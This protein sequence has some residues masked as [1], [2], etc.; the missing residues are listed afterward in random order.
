MPHFRQVRF[1]ILLRHRLIV[2]HYRATQDVRRGSSIADRLQYRDQMMQRGWPP[3]AQDCNQEKCE[4]VDEITDLA[5]QSGM[6]VDDVRTLARL[7]I[8]GAGLLR[9]RMLILRIDSDAFAQAEPEAF[10]E[11][12]KR[13]SRCRDHGLCAQELVRDAIEPTRPDWRGYCPNAASLSALSALW[14][15]TGRLIADGDNRPGK[16]DNAAS[17]S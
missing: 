3:F 12:Q 11:L 17:G 6:S 4:Q 7:G 13:C 9:R 15:N 14:V 5:R 16:Q 10:R 8:H 1:H 2:D